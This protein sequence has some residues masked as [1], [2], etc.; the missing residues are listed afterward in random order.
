VLSD[1]QIQL[2]MKQADLDEADAVCR[3]PHAEL[4]FWKAQAEHFRAQLLEQLR[5]RAIRDR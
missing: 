5:P 3:E 4:A 2:G 1:V